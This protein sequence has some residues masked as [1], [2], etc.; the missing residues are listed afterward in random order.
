[1]RGLE[2]KTVL[3]TGSGRGIGR[4]IAR[5]LAEEGATV[6]VNDIDE[7]NA[8]ETADIIADE[9]GDSLTA[10]AD[11][12]DF[13]AMQTTVRD[14]AEAEGLDVIVNNAGWDRIE[15]FLDQDPDVWDDLIDLNLKGQMNG[16][17]AAAEHFVETGTSGT[18]INISS[19]AARVGSSGEAVY[20]GAKGGVISFTKTLARELARNDVNC[21]VVAPGPADTPL[22]RE[23]RETDLGEKILGGMTGQVPLGRMAEPEDIAGA[24]AFFASEDAS[25]V[26]GQ[27][28]SVSGGLTMT[29]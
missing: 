15:W 4:S 19:D 24:V 18:I 7:A 9:G 13:E 16:S 22:T 8:R 25:F 1:M 5:R 21:N 14:I 10:I 2:D 29:D 6:A 17:R 26:T 28:L 11:V 3:V 27:V 12:T 23:M 20:A